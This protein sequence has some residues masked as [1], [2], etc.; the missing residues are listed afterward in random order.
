MTNFK[1]F[2]P[3]DPE[4]KLDYLFDWAPAKN[5]RGLSNWLREGEIIVSYE[6]TV[7]DGLD[8]VSDSLVDDDTAVSVWFDNGTGAQCEVRC[9]IVTNQDREDT[10]TAIIPISPR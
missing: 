9:S 8:K 10:R 5:N 3:K 6:L 1:S 2:P 7:P 4:S